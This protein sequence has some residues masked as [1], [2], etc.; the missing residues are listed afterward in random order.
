MTSVDK[1]ALLCAWLGAM[2][3]SI[4]AY[5]FSPYPAIIVQTA[6]SLT[7]G[8]TL[9]LC[10]LL[11]VMHSLGQ[12][13]RR[14]IVAAI[15]IWIPLSISLA[16]FY[17]RGERRLSDSKFL[18]PLDPLL[19]WIV[20][21]SIILY[22]LLIFLIIRP[23]F[24]FRDSGIRTQWG[25]RTIMS[26]ALLILTHI[27]GGLILVVNQYM[28][29]SMATAI[30]VMCLVG[31]VARKK[32]GEILPPNGANTAEGDSF[33]V[34]ALTVAVALVSVMIS[35]TP[36]VHA[37]IE[38]YIRQ[39]LFSPLPLAA[40][41]IVYVS[42]AHHYFSERIPRSSPTYMITAGILLIAAFILAYSF[43]IT[44]EFE[45]FVSASNDADALSG[46][47]IVFSYP[48]S[49]IGILWIVA[50]FFPRRWW[51]Q[52]LLMIPISIAWIL[53]GLIFLLIPIAWPLLAGI[54]LVVAF[55]RWTPPSAKASPRP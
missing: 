7:G 2:I 40:L 43:T 39:S 21:I 23:L 3:C 52:M 55:L 24:H 20:G 49:L 37:L 8:L 4:S 42:V 19:P 18:A 50:L 46:A 29:F 36:F 25:S 22:L 51:M 33:L 15:G 13:K 38:G 5:L 1:K 54:L 41:P 48:I 10:G 28:F 9:S 30:S 16:F 53:L 45:K 11:I 27:I 34:F 17:V 14:G 31:N 32:E 47:Y 6:V 44:E 12:I 26:I 35:L